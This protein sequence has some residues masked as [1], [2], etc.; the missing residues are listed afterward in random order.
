MADASV[1]FRPDPASPRVLVLDDH[2]GR[3][4]AVRDV[5]ELAGCEVGEAASLKQAAETLAA[6]RV[7]V[8]VVVD[9][10]GR[11]L[12]AAIRALGCRARIVAV[13][14]TCAQARACGSDS[15]LVGQF[16]ARELTKAVVG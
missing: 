4:D 6:G 2:A 10:P 15:C 5:L 12:T 7:D 9:N 3:R 14:E 1:P 11:Q 8:V 13:C 16:S